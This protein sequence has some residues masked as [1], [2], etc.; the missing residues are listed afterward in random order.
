[1]VS[2]EFAGPSGTAFNN[3]LVAGKSYA[4]DAM[5][6]FT[7]KSDVGAYGYNPAGPEAVQPHAVM[8]ITGTI[9]GMTNPTFSY[10]PN[11]NMTGGAG[12][13]IA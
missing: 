6:N 8:S 12:R 7:S 11:G 9:N 5:G 3:G 13:T 1:M 4:Y 2:L 10:D